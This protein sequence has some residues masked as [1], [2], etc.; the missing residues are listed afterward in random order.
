MLSDSAIGGRGKGDGPPR[1]SAKWSL[2]LPCAVY[3]SHILHD[4]RKMNWLKQ[5]GALV[6]F[7]QIFSLLWRARWLVMNY[8]VK[9]TS[10]GA[11]SSI[12]WSFL[13]CQQLTQMNLAN[14]MLSRDG[15]ALNPQVQHSAAPAAQRPVEGVR[16][17]TQ[18]CSSVGWVQRHVE[19][20]RQCSGPI[21]TSLSGLFCSTVGCLGQVLPL[22]R[23][24][25]MPSVMPHL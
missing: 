6:L 15:F 2:A 7:H 20:S 22:Y 23:L 14:R 11:E 9:M 21:Q 16:S 17:G 19:Y 4:T 1:F 10:R 12:C 8:F 5:G 24:I 13:L 18:L 3:I 25:F